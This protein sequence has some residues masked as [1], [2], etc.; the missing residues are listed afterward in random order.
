MPKP[1]SKIQIFFRRIENY[2]SIDLLLVFLFSLLLGMALGRGLEG[3]LTN[4]IL[5]SYLPALATLVAA[6]IGAKYA[7][8]LQHQKEEKE[9]IRK[10]LIKGNLT[11]FNISRMIDNLR[12]YDDQVIKPV[13]N[14]K[15]RSLNMRP[16]LPIK[17]GIS[18]N[19]EDISFLFEHEIDIVS[20]VSLGKAKYNTIFEAI[21]MRS[22]IHLEELQPKLEINGYST[23]KY[24]TIDQLKGFIGERLF[25]TLDE[26]TTEIIELVDDGLKH[27]LLVASK[28]SQ[29]LMKT[30][31][32]EKIFVIAPPNPASQ[33]LI[34][35]VIPDAIMEK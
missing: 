17:D 8:D 18:I 34:K 10:N 6:F 21:Q 25:A 13:K 15:H 4:I 5:D 35:E 32:Q 23:E 12:N 14:D 30:Y 28:L 2:K 11:I 20:D 19:A 31:P 24:Y 33:T 29:A 7:F 16:T 22:K 3:K 1:R 27:L 26:S 9:T